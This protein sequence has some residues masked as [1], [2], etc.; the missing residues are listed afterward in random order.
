MF[1]HSSS[2]L[3]SCVL[4][5]HS[6]VSA[7]LPWCFEMGGG[8]GGGGEVGKNEKDGGRYVRVVKEGEK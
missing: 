3:Q 5:T 6:S 1:S 2:A 7:W 4:D 8:G